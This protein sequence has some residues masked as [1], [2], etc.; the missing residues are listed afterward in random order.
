MLMRELMVF[1]EQMFQHLQQEWVDVLRRAAGLWTPRWRLAAAPAG[2][3]QSAEKF[4]VAASN[5]GAVGNAV[6]G[7]LAM[8]AELDEVSI[9]EDGAVRSK[10]W[11][12]VSSGEGAAAEENQHATGGVAPEGGAASV[13]V[14]EEQLA[15]LWLPGRIM[16]I[17]VSNGQCF[18]S[19]VSRDFPD[20]RA[21]VLQGNIFEDHRSERIHNA[22]LEVRAVRQSKRPAPAWQGYDASDLCA[23]CK[24]SFT[25]NSTFT[26]QA[27]EF[28]DKYNCRSCGRLVCDA[29]SKQ[30]RSIPQ[31]GHIMPKRICDQCLYKG[32]FA[33]F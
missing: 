21:I 19:E 4:I 30:R 20:L 18:A 32:D 5:S 29:C 9:G 1:R 6:Q 13:L 17:Y 15:P 33:T 3:P 28:R 27:Q 31:Y 8:H 23:C 25:W 10:A 11:D 16:H 7:Q 12:D 22:L 14:E 2:V 24:C 26:G